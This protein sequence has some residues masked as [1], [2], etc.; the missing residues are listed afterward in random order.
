M[1]NKRNG[2]S[3]S[4]AG[5]LG[6]IASKISRQK[7]I[8]EKINNYILNPNYCKCC[9]KE[10]DYNHRNNIFCSKSCATKYNNINRDQSTY[11]KQRT[12]L[13]KTIS[14]KQKQKIDINCD[15]YKNGVRD[16]K[17]IK[18]KYC[19]YCGAIKGQCRDL[20][21]CERY[22]LYKSLEKFGFNKNIIGTEKIIDEFYRVRDLIEK[23]YNENSSN[24]EKLV[25]EFSY[26]SG[27]ANFIKLLKS[28]N[29][30][31]RN[32]SDANIKTWLD[33]KLNPVVENQYKSGWHTTWDNRKV[34]LRSS[35]EFEYARQLDS[36][37]IYYEVESLRIKYYNT[38]KNSIRCAVPDF[39]IPNEKKIV[40]IKSNWTIKGRVQ[41]L[42]DKFKA[43]KEKGYIPILILEKSEVDIYT[44]QDMT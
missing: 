1:A 10:L 7:I 36:S 12:T 43:Y 9:K 19:K 22:R 33:G 39:I 23:F 4:E 38:N 29:I 30:P 17:P 40:E 27:S 25:K 37:K 24:N 3:C 35:Y 13:L 42:K 5:K 15:Q 11:N 20:F 34:Y 28:L 6:S 21:V 2:M 8:K 16:N 44:L 31:V 18:Y 14:K 32:N 26:T 41:E